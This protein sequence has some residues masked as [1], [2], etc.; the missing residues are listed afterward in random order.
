MSDELSL[1]I[2]VIYLL[3]DQVVEVEEGD[4]EEAQRDIDGEASIHHVRNT[5][6]SLPEQI[7]VTDDLHIHPFVSLLSVHLGGVVEK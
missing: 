5:I 3:L 7:D 2:Q 4:N 1:Q 6:D